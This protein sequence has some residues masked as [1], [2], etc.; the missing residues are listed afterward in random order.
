MVKKVF[1]SKFRVKY[2]AWLL[3]LVAALCVISGGCGSSSSHIGRNEDEANYPSTSV[4][5]PETLF[6]ISNLNLLLTMDIDDNNI[7]DFLDFEGVPQFHIDN[8]GSDASGMI[9]T[10]HFRK[11][12][13]FT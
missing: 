13:C 10:K 7:P 8:S 12:F 9:Y 2:L 1:H 4:N 6:N 5:C 3:L 11:V